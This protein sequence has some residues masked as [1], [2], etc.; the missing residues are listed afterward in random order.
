[1]SHS[2]KYFGHYVWAGIENARKVSY[3]NRNLRM[4][5]T[6]FRKAARYQ[7][8]TKIRF[9]VLQLF[10][11]VSLNGWAHIHSFIIWARQLMLRMHLSLG[12]IVQPSRIHLAQI[13]QP[14]AF[15]VEA[16]V[17]YWGCAYFFWFDKQIPKNAVALTSQRLVAANN[18]L[19]CFGLLPSES[20]GWIPI[21]QAHSIHVPSYR[22]MSH[23][24]GN[25]QSQEM[26]TQL[27]QV[28]GSF[29]TWFAYE[30]LTMSMIW[31]I[32]PGSMVLILSPVFYCFSCQA[33]MYSKSRFRTK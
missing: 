21:K 2:N 19:H 32:S 4:C 6:N 10:L 8:P 29:L 20:A 16:E 17:S 9:S 22:G 13:Q 15:Y 27:K 5:L 14:C 7:V 25:C 30:K 11:R 23:E 12:L 18:M 3:F 26:P 31:Q 1:M 24:D 33:S 28:V